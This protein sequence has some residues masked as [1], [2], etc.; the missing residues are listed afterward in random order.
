MMINKAV[1]TSSHTYSLLHLP[2][3]SAAEYFA[4]LSPPISLLKQAISQST[5]GVYKSAHKW[6]SASFRAATMKVSDWLGICDARNVK[7]ETSLLLCSQA[8]KL[9]G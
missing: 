1:K 5:K 4:R 3:V 6:L 7:S 2:T 9:C 8:R